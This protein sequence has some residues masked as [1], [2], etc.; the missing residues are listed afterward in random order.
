MVRKVVFATV[1]NVFFL[2]IIEQDTRF[3]RK[4]KVNYFIEATVNYIRYLDERFF[5]K[6]TYNSSV[7][8]CEPM[9]FGYNNNEPTYIPN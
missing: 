5:I 9:V 1:T 8:F 6:K 7:L 4:I 3:H 2:N